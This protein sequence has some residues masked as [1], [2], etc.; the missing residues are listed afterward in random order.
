M[1]ANEG[2][3][4]N[5]ED[6]TVA[7]ISDRTTAVSGSTAKADDAGRDM[8]GGVL[9]RNAGSSLVLAAA[10]PGTCEELSEVEGDGSNEM[11]S[12]RDDRFEDE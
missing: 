12:D 11:F 10:N 2:G 4:R 9:V 3:R 8:L 6:D 7:T 5:G 1:T